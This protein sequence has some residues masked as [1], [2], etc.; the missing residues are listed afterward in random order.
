MMRYLT[1]PWV[2]R[3]KY[4]KRDRKSFNLAESSVN[5][6]NWGACL[7]IVC[8]AYN[9]HSACENWK[10]GFSSIISASNGGSGIKS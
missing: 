8:R 4:C 1:Y 5:A 10:D 6:K 2:P 9:R 7:P 3:A